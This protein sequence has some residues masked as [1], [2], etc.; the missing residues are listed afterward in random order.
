MDV[1]VLRLLLAD[2]DRDDHL[3]F[4]EVL[5]ELL[6]STQLST[7]NDGEQ[8]MQQLTDQPAPLPDVLFLDLNMPRKNGLQCLEEIKRDEQLKHLPVIIFSTSLQEDVVD[9]V[10]KNGAQHYIRKPAEFSRL[11]KAIHHALTLVAQKNSAQPTREK[12]VITGNSIIH[13]EV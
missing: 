5:S 8:L 3:L 1:Q 11:K 10:Y 12:F 9:L 7:V 4:S 13:S 6:F 2:D